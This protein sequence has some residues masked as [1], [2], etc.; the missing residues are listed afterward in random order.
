MKHLYTLLLLFITY[1]SVA[2]YTDYVG[3]GHSAGVTV[4]SS[5]EQ[6]KPNWT[7][8]ASAENTINGN[9]LDARLLE[10]S[11]FLAQATFGTSKTYIQTVATNSF[12]SWIDNQFTLPT[13]A[14]SLGDAT[15]TIYEDAKARYYSN[16][17]ANA[18]T[19]PK[20]SHFSYA[21]WEHNMTNDDLLR[22]RV[23]LALSE[24]FS[25]SDELE[26]DKWGE[27]SGYFYDV[28]ANDAFAN[29]ETLLMD[30]T[31][32]PMMSRY[33]TYY[34]NPKSD[35]AN[36]QFPDENYARE[37]MQLFTIG[38]YELNNDGTYVLDASNHRIPTYDNDDIAEFAKVFTGLGAGAALYGLTPSFGLDFGLVDKGVPL[39]MYDTYHEPGE[40]HLL[41]GYTI[42]SGQTGMQ[43]V[44]DAINH[45]FNHPNI[46]PFI[47]ERLIQ[48]L[49]KSNP[50][51][52]Y[53]NDVANAFNNTN[54]VRGDMKAVIK[55]ILLHPEA[56][57][58]S[59][60]TNPEQ[61]KLREPMIR[62][63]NLLRQ[64]TLNNPSAK[65][66]NSG[67][68]FQNYTYQAPLS[69][70]SIF[71]FYYP[72]FS[73][74]GP[75]ADANLVAPEFQIHDSYTS[76][77]YVN[78]FDAFIHD[79]IPLFG[80][81]SY[82]GLTDVTFDFTTLKYLAKDDEVLLNHLDMLFTNGQ[83]SNETRTIIK[84]AMAN[85]TSLDDASLLNKSKIAL[86][87][88]LVSPDYTIQK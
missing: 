7:E 53:I 27:G 2:Q 11:R 55:A 49:V 72:D 51:P 16:G 36:N 52:Q 40:K 82:L 17:G 9:G 88:I 60:S 22:Q 56:R 38:L 31:R 43:D 66:W 18:Y 32:Q 85:Y 81:Q 19:G 5:S 3:A 45:L 20:S 57:S 35:I 73:P 67:N 34:N 71:N 77:G 48:R 78:A 15:T 87:L 44:T 6:T 41:N 10:T 79:E 80:N 12:E 65:Y 24:I 46:A 61:G 25:F 62:Y 63:F 69:A 37:V 84:T 39:N 14:V 47:A 42:P 74:N 76:V 13:T 23:A 28:L 64:I 54:G 4:S 58:C 30:V 21:W 75:I 86:W 1:S 83:L 68:Y 70:L 33:L 50:T 59:W 8:T 29:F 26:K